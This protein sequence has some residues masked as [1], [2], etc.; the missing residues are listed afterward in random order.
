MKK[1]KLLRTI[2]LV[3]LLALI[4][5]QFIPVD[6][7]VPEADPG[8]DFTMSYEM[9]QEFVSLVREACYDCHSY[10]AEYP[11]YAKVAPLNFW[12]QGHIDEGREHL[13]FSIWTTYDIDRKLHK[14][15]EMVEEVEEGH[16]PLKSFT[17]THPEAR[18]TD[19]QRAKLVRW[20]EALSH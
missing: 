8:Q 12:I 4:V 9:P 2:G 10:E 6:R 3:L 11:W 14:L 15:E 20:F 13:N 5:I 16:M 19:E 7:S 17:W 1:G 18:L